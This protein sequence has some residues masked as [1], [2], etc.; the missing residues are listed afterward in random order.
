MTHASKKNVVF[1]LLVVAAA[2][3]CIVVASMAGCG[4]QRTPPPASAEA[5]RPPET[6]YCPAP[7]TP[8]IQRYMV[9]RNSN[10]V[11]QLAEPIEVEGLVHNSDHRRPTRAK[12]WLDKGT[13]AVPE[14][15]YRIEKA[16]PRPAVPFQ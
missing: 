2:A 11:I 10:F 7:E 1:A 8:Q 9:T 13:W 3:V 14:G 4:K 15:R 16:E 5:D 12:V 6:A